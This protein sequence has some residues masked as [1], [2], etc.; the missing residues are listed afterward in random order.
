[1]FYAMITSCSLS[2]QYHTRLRARRVWE[3][4]PSGR[5]A[6]ESLQPSRDSRK[7]WRAPRRRWVFRDVFLFSPGG[8][9]YRNDYWNKM[10]AC[11]CKIRFGPR[12][13]IISSQKHNY[14]N[15]FCCKMQHLDRCA[16]KS[17]QIGFCSPSARSS[18]CPFVRPPNRPPVRMTIRSSVGRR[19]AVC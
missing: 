3:A 15:M 6:E 16:S 12:A 18:V 11:I 4:M 17:G 9:P 8:F 1:M 19:L 7:V 14:L 10:E 5:R 2:I 13:G